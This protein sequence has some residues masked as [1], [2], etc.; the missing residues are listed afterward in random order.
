MIKVTLSATVP[1]VQ[2]GNLVP[3]VEVEADSYDEAMAQAEAH[4]TGFWNKHVE[5]GKELKQA[6][7]KK[8]RAFVGG[9]INYDDATHTYSNDAGEVYLSGSQYAKQF[10][11]PFDRDSITGKMGAKW[12]VEPTDIADM[13]ELA[14]EASRTF[15]TAVHAALQLYGQYGD[16]AKSVEKEYH[17]HSQPDLKRIVE[18]FYAEHK[19]KA[20][21]E[22]LVVDHNKKHAGQID[23]LEVLGDNHY[24]V[25]DYKTNADLPK[26]KLGVYWKQLEFYS[27][28][29]RAAGCK[30]EPEVVYH[31]DGKKWVTYTNEVA[32]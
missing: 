18:S 28:I 20:K 26:E 3:T 1:V 6:K 9:D 2:Y 14:A 5:K 30:V 31:Y 11:K 24:R 13:W 19:E 12:G 32:L 4:I 16:L 22:V 8:L 10:E 15:G 25:T 17:L 29:L 23:R 27:D 7:G 21:C